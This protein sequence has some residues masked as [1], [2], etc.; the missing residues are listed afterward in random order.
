MIYDQELVV[1][2]TV[3]NMCPQSNVTPTSIQTLHMIS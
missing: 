1:Y 2:C 3:M